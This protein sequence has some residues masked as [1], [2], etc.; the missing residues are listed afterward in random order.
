[1]VRSANQAD[2]SPLVGKR[3]LFVR[4]AVV[5]LFAL[6]TVAAIRYGIPPKRGLALRPAFLLPVALIALDVGLPLPIAAIFGAGQFPV[7]AVVICYWLGKRG[8]HSVLMR[9]VCCYGAL[10]VGALVVEWLI[11]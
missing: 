4:F 7:L 3:L 8:W 2:G 6:L 10:V 11:A 5:V 9:T 1:M